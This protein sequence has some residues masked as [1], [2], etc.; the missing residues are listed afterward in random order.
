MDKNH[1]EFHP[2][3]RL[4]NLERQA[5]EEFARERPDIWKVTRNSELAA[6]VLL[7]AAID[8][9]NLTEPE[10]LRLFLWQSVLRY[11]FLSLKFM[12]T[13]DLDAAYTLLRNAT[14]LSRDIVCIAN[15]PQMTIRW[16]E[17][18]TAR[19]RD[20]QFRFNTSDPAQA[21]VFSF[22]KI[23]SNWG[24]HGHFCG[25]YYGQMISRVG[26]DGV[27]AL[28][29]VSEA[30]VDEALVLW[31]ISFLS[32]QTLCAKQFVKDHPTEFSESW[33]L[34]CEYGDLIHD[35]LADLNTQCK[36]SMIQKNAA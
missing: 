19:K 7:A 32:I 33:A 10:N 13:R 24:T 22:Y 34:F 28:T 17:S 12:V 26:P 16:Y 15:D 4:L 8:L 29:Q 1:D 2:L 31:I 27:F 5:V 6:H 3:E 36:T 25:L 20:S 11:Q 14:E 23:A 35:F 18:K 9:P 30:G 21:S